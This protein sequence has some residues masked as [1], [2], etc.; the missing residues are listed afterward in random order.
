VS[1]AIAAK[2]IRIGRFGEGVFVGDLTNMR[3]L[4]FRVVCL[5][6]VSERVFPAPSPRDPLLGA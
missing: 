5:L 2:T 3:G 6:G 1:A 4:S